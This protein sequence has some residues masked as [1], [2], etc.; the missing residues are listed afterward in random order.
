MRVFE[1]IPEGE[2]FLFRVSLVK[3]PAVEATLLK[4][5]NEKPMYFVNEE[6]RVIYSVAMRPDKLIFRNNISDTMTP[7]SGY[8]FFSKETIEKCQQNYFKNNRNASTNINHED[9]EVKGVYCFESWI[10]KDTAND[11]ANAIG[12]EV[13]QGDWVQAFKIENDEVWEQVKAGNLDGLS[14]E[15]YMS[16][17]EVI[18]NKPQIQMSTEKTKDNLWKML[19]SF[20]AGENPEEKPKEEDMAVDPN[21]PAVEPTAEP[22][23]SLEEE[24]KATIETLTKENE[25]L[26]AKIIEMEAGQVTKETELETMKKEFETFKANTPAATSIPT[27]PKVEVVKKSYEEMTNFEKLKFNKENGIR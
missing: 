21:M 8:V 10:V 1:Q 5:Q 15:T 18:N 9:N 12:L 25:D 24:L 6:K 13:M 27:T 26:K 23:V 22:V 17:K 11:K 19:T 2:D 3:D 7:E 20:F 14:I 4:F 16:K